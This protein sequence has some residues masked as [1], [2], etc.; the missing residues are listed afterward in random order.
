MQ[1]Q[2]DLAHHPVAYVIATPP[3]EAVLAGL[4]VGMVAMGIVSIQ[5]VTYSSRFFREQKVTIV[6]I[7]LVFLANLAALLLLGQGLYYSSITRV[8]RGVLKDVAFVQK[9]TMVVAANMALRSIVLYTAG[10]VTASQQNPWIPAEYI[11]CRPPRHR[12]LWYTG[13]LQLISFNIPPKARR[14][15]PNT[16]RQ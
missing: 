6:I 7:T 3:T 13:R 4:V 5:A 15:T 2:S 12:G 1:P 8:R 16:H 10:L 11:D 9:Y 14:C